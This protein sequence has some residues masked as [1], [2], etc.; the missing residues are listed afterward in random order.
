M[1]HREIVSMVLRH[2]PPPY[3]PWELGFTCEARQKLLAISAA[4]RR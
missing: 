4:K 3:V 1:T 2:E